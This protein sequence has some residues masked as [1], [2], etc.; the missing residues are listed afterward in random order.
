MKNA[1][2]S[3]CAQAS[4]YGC[5]Q[6]HPVKRH[7]C[8][9]FFFTFIQVC[10]DH[11]TL[12]APVDL[13]NKHLAFWGLWGFPSWFFFFFNCFNKFQSLQLRRDPAMSSWLWV[14]RSGQARESCDCL[15]DCL[16]VT[17][18]RRRDHSIQ[19]SDRGWAKEVQQRAGIV[20]WPNYS[21][22]SQLGLLSFGQKIELSLPVGWCSFL[23]A[24]ARCL[25]K[26]FDCG[27]AFAWRP[28]TD[29]R[30]GRRQHSSDVVMS[31]SHPASTSSSS[32]SASGSAQV[33]QRK[34]HVVTSPALDALTVPI[35]DVLP[36]A[37]HLVPAPPWPSQAKGVLFASR[38]HSQTSGKGGRTSLSLPPHGSCVQANLNI[39]RPQQAR[40]HPQGRGD[41]AED[42]VATCR[43]RH[44]R[45]Y[46]TE[47]S[48]MTCGQTTT[49]RMSDK[50]RELAVE[51]CRRAACAKSW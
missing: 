12:P 29:S 26:L 10:R 36:L 5:L 30:S 34:P 4:S 14:T 13:R 3:S 25:C 41:G 33:G 17:S 15:S 42:R 8:F 43:P 40:L 37:H 35:S 32:P 49:Q 44:E 1:S 38:N 6:F 51:S 31:R 27:F 7:S 28:H 11:Q 16:S 24:D 48:E 9:F 50:D 47:S 21:Q 39:R 23:L 20:P 22:R 19:G 2:G 45:R 18:I 46:A